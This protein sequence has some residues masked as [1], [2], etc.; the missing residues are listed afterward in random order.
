MMA[1]SLQSIQQNDGW[2]FSILIIVFACRAAR[3]ILPYGTTSS[4]CREFL[5]F[6]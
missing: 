2:R 6:L 3:Q 4:S 5:P 1:Q